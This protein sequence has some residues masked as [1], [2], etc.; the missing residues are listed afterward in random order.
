MNAI[1]II[2]KTKKSIELSDSEISWL[3]K[4]YTDGMI[5]DYQMSAW[6]MAVCINGLTERETLS[7]TYAMRDSGEIMNLDIGLTADKHSTGGVGDKTSLI[8]GPAAAACGVCV[9]KMSGRGLGHTGGTIDKLESISGF[10]TD[11]TIAEFKKILNETGFAI[12]SQNEKLCPADKKIYALRNS[13]GTVDSIPLICASIMSKK[14]AM[15]ADCLVL[16]VKYGSGAFM[17]TRSDAEKLASL[18]E[19]IGTSAGKRC[20]A[21][22]TDMESPLGKNI[23]NALE[24][25]E[26]VEIL[27]GKKKGRL[28]DTCIELTAAI[29]EIAGK[30]KNREE[31]VNLAEEAISSGKALEIFRKTVALQGG[32]PEICNNTSLLPRADYKYKVKAAYDMKITGFNCEE[33]GMV[34]LLLGAGRISKD[35]P[36]DMSAGIEM[37]V[38]T[39]S[40]VSAGD[41]IMTLYSSVRSDFSDIALRALKAIDY[42]MFY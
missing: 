29:L 10:R 15:N 13:T 12:I 9:A 30:G 2:N 38:E 14:L 37:N 34:S 17:K 35:D 7:L 28:Y 18:M 32:D 11:L 5:P 26:A 23:G 40:I 6:L 33:I 42:Q 20:K 1:D 21:L 16:D 19:K 27:Q 8:I 22:V 41:T 25:K 39:G 4:S 3:V 31:C 24:V 36:V